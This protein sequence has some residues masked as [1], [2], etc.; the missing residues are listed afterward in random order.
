MHGAAIPDMTK[1]AV[2]NAMKQASARMAD[3]TAFEKR[4]ETA[5]ANVAAQTMNALN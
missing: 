5:L 1:A 3:R 2:Q 4:L